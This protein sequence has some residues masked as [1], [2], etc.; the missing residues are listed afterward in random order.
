MIVSIFPAAMFVRFERNTG[1]GGWDESSFIPRL[2]VQFK[3]M[4]SNQMTGII[5]ADVE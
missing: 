3:R 1:A 2:R 4:V 5:E